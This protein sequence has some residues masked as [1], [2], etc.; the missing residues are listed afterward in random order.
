MITLSRL[1]SFLVLGLSLVTPPRVHAVETDNDAFKPIFNGKDLNGWEGNTNFWSVKD[2]MIQ[3]QTT[4]ENPTKGN[5]FLIWRAGTVD[6]FEFRWSFRMVGGNSGVQ[7]R[8]KDFGNYVVGGYQADFEAGD[9]YS[10]I[11]YEERGAR[12]IMAERGQKVE[13]DKDGKKT[14][15]GSVGDSKAIQA[16]IKKEGWNEYQILVQGNHI[17]H[18]INGLTT[19]DVIDG[20][21]KN[22][23]FSGILALQLHAGPPMLVQFKDLQLKRLKL[24]NNRKKIV[25]VAG[26]ASHSRGD[27]EFNAGVQL[28]HKC[29]TGQP[30]VLST[31]YLSG[32]PMDT[33][34]FDNAD[35]ILF[36]ADGGAGHPA[37]QGDHLAILDALADKGVGLAFA[38]YGVEV[39]KERGGK[40]FLKWAGGYF[41]ADWSINPTWE[42][43]VT[44]PTHEVTQGVQPFTIM[45]EW[46]YNM[47][48]RPQMKGVSPVVF[49]IPP[50]STRQGADSPHGGNKF[51]REQ[52]GTKRPEVLGWVSEG[53]NRGFGFTG[54]H[55]HKNWGDDNFRKLILNALIWTAHLEVPTGGVMSTVTAEDLARNLDTKK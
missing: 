34:A 13:W 27:H 23:V 1:F 43:S 18:K 37:I 30:G 22:Q 7:Y 32:W 9:T 20:D 38:H 46:Y 41:E 5:T 16:A 15:L 44:L 35:S 28:L 47:R 50:D 53:A 24:S 2:G 51:V 55:F 49:A 31:Y 40:E 25:L 4:A 6:D 8:S 19:V 29:L 52:Q 36:Y 33:T 14:V 21:P 10:G 42:A 3:G 11:L 45:D 39:P 54:G 17:I 12:G 26:K 48:F